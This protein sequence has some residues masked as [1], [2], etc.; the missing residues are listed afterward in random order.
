MSS[1]YNVIELG[2]RNNNIS[3]KNPI[4]GKLNIILLNNPKQKRKLQGKLDIS[5]D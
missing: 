4:I 3:R 5:T 2:I 1:D